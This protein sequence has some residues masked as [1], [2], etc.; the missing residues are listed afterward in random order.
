VWADEILI[1]NLHKA[2]PVSGKPTTGFRWIRA[3]S[4]SAFLSVLDKMQI[5]N[6]FDGYE[7]RAMV[8]FITAFSF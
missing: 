5:A 1:P 8:S 7:V 3:T 6:K 2:L 4:N